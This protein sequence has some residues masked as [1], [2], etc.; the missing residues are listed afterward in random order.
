MA[1][2]A[3]KFGAEPLLASVECIFAMVRTQVP[4]PTS[5]AARH[6]CFSRFGHN[7]T[8]IKHPPAVVPAVSSHSPRIILR[9]KRRRL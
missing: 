8:G 5:P 6:R 4:L 2:W 3:L 7:H 9:L 1:T